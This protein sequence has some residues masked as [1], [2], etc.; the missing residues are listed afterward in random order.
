MTRNKLT[1]VVLTAMLS[2]FLAAP[3][4]ASAGGDQVNRPPASGAGTQQAGGDLP[5]W[6][7]RAEQSAS[8]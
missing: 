7:P 6:A 2:V 5:D 3:A 1:A 4:A 8:L